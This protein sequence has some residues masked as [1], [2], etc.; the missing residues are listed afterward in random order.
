MLLGP[1]RPCSSICLLLWQTR[2]D[3]YPWCTGDGSH[4]ANFLFLPRTRCNSQNTCSRRLRLWQRMMRKLIFIKRSCF[5]LITAAFSCVRGGRG[6]KQAE[7]VT[8]EALFPEGLEPS[9]WDLLR[10]G[11]SPDLLMLC[12]CFRWLGGLGRIGPTLW[13]CS[14]LQ[15]HLHV[16]T[17]ISHHRK[18]LSPSQKEYICAPPSTSN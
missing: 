18:L 15:P 12:N 2:A 5:P 6:L 1:R 8:A 17:F 3:Y 16:H 14:Q 13:N 4:Y 10:P 11:S 9:L 7:M